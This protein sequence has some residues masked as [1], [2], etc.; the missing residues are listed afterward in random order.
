VSD[1]NNSQKQF[2]VSDKNNSQKQFVPTCYSKFNFEH[3]DLQTE[4]HIKLFTLRILREKLFVCNFVFTTLWFLFLR[5]IIWQLFAQLWQIQAISHLSRSRSLS[6]KISE[7][8]NRSAASFSNLHHLLENGESLVGLSLVQIE[9]YLLRR[10][11]VRMCLVRPGM[12]ARSW[13]KM[14]KRKRIF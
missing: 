4:N 14:R 7:K 5:K 9:D 12:T 3:R 1:K 10:L 13:R 11:S 6:R 8:R 2:I